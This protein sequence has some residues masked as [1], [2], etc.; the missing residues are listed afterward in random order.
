MSLFDFDNLTESENFAKEEGKK[1]MQRAIENALRSDPDWAD[2]AYE[3]LRIYASRNEFFIS[4]DVSD[5]SRR[6]NINQP[7]TD[8][9]WGSVYRKACQDGLMEIDG[10]GRSRRRH[11]SICPRWRSLIYSPINEGINGI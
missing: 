5:A 10:V 11:G 2:N 9:A 4:E 6:E 1:G 7:P 3:F 8:R